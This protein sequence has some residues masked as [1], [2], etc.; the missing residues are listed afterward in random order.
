MTQAESRLSSSII[1]KLN[2]LPDTFAWKNH[3]S[4]YMIGGLPDII[5]CHQGRFIGLEVKRP[6]KKDTV[7]PTQK[8]VHGLIR[9][10][11]GKVYV[12]S[13]IDEVMTKVLVNP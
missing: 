13:S 2:A 3:G 9:R 6:G 4:E 5:V 10:A 7:S 1:R 11:G 12:V 8:L